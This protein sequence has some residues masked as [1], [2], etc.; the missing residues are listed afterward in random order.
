MK[1]KDRN[2]NYLERKRKVTGAKI[3]Y[4]FLIGRIALK[5]LIR[6]T[7]SKMGAVYMDSP[8]SK[9][10]NKGFIKKNKINL[11]EYEEKKYRSYNDLFIRRIKKE[12]RPINDSPDILISPCDSKLLVYPINNES[13]LKIKDSVYTVSDLVGG[14]KLKK[15]RNG[16]ALVFRLEV[17]DYHHY[18]YIDNGTKDENV[19]IKG[20]LHTVQPV[21]SKY[22]VYKRNAREYTILHTENFG[23]IVQIEV[24][25]MM[26]GRI[27]NHHGVYKFLKGEEK[28]YFEFGGS[29][30]VLLLKKGVVK[31]DSDIL[32]NS[33]RDIETVVKMGEKIGKKRNN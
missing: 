8:L 29:T 18:C 3:L 14:K 5:V 16:I 22:K 10:W 13:S 15:Y 12:Y 27:V 2:G 30:I 26:V 23:D 11:E 1:I 7:V 32:E 33:M 24:G 25:A 9:V 19:Y 4:T 21:S 6:P 20:V 28:G 31:L 17:N